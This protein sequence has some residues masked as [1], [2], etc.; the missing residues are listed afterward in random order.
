MTS[1]RKP[2]G[3]W[4]LEN[5]RADASKYRTKAEWRK[6]SASAYAIALAKGL[7]ANCCAHMESMRKPDGYW[8]K[9]R[10]LSSALRYSTIIEWS[11]REPKAYDAA[12]RFGWYREATKHMTRVLSHGEHTI[13]KY[14]LQHDIAFEYQRRFGTIRAKRTMPFDFHLPAFGLVIEYQGRQHFESSRTSM[15]RRNLPDQQRRDAL[16]LQLAEAQG[17]SYLAIEDQRVAAIE[18]AISGRLRQIAEMRGQPL[19]LRRRLLTPQEA[20]TLR[21]LGRWNRESVLVDAMKYRTISEWQRCGNAACQ[22][23]YQRGWIAE[24][25]AHMVQVQKPK[26]YWTKE[27]ILD[28]ARRFAARSAWNDSSHSAYVRARQ[29]GWFDEATAHMPRRS[30]RLRRG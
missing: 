16:K 23:A 26:G 17:L 15:Y 9:D 22:I 21:N 27:R 20:I 7:M 24:A 18:G 4:S 5:L 3:Y 1:P 29:M 2:M 12:K 11:L 14:L 30:V 6:C 19:S 10:C 25:T 8:T 28:D 13:Y